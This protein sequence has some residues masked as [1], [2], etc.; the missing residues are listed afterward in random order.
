MRPNFQQLYSQESIEF[1]SKKFFTELTE[2]YKAF[3]HKKPVYSDLE[4]IIKA[5]TNITVEIVDSGYWATSILMLGQ[6]HVLFKEIFD[7]YKV[8]MDIDTESD[9]KKLLS[10]DKA[11]VLKGGVDRVKSQVTGIFEKIKFT[12]WI[13]SKDIKGL[14]TDEECAAV[15]LHEVG[16]QFTTFEMLGDETYKNY[17]LSNSLKA[18]GLQSED[19]N[20]KVY[21]AKCAKD[22]GLDDTHTKGL[23]NAKTKEDA[24]LVILDDQRVSKSITGPLQSALKGSTYQSVNSEWV[25]DDFATRHGAG[26]HITTGLSKMID[27]NSTARVAFNVI[28]ILGHYVWPTVMLGPLGVALSALFF[29]SNIFV[30]VHEQ[31]TKRYDLDAERFK[32]IKNTIVLK[33]R[34]GDS[35]SKQQLLECL[36]SI[37]T[38]ERCINTVKSEKPLISKLHS[39]IATL[40]NKDMSLSKKQEEFQK[41]LEALANNDLYIKAFKAKLAA[42]S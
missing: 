41:G 12:L 2:Y 18:A 1:Q 13:S 24:Y 39:A 22:L 25:A 40:V 3:D 17:A 19:P 15:T 33:L 23:L 37:D 21:L 34:T 27:K 5:N 31:K 4:R 20:K 30:E 28:T 6:N 14:L 32:R 11:T 8:F 26:D 42:Q 29:V 16:H 35:F 7:Q 36:G 38:I 9:L 10:N